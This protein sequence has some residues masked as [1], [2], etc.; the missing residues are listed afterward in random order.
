MKPRTEPESFHTCSFCGRAQNEVRL[1]VGRAGVS[2][3][4]ECVAICMATYLLRG[5]NLFDDI[6]AKAKIMAAEPDKAS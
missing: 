3:C 4:N 2:I 5:G 1:M 6:L